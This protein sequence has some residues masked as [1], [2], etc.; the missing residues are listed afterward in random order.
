L[1]Q[2]RAQIGD[3][4]NCFQKAHNLWSKVLVMVEELTHLAISW[5]S[6]MC[7]DSCLEIKSL[8]RPSE[9][10]LE[11]EIFLFRK[12]FDWW[13]RVKFSQKANEVCQLW[14]GLSRKTRTWGDVLNL[15]ASN[16]R[17]YPLI[18]HGSNKKFILPAGDLPPMRDAPNFR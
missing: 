10:W 9:T 2:T 11:L 13:K 17:R 15:G 7:S 3:P 16:F 1:K 18:V 6:E 4:L 14:S 5:P 8:G 12:F